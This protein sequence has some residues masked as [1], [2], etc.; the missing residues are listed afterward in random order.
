MPECPKLSENQIKKILNCQDSF[1][2]KMQ[3]LDKAA[4]KLNR[5][6]VQLEAD[7][8]Q[9]PEVKANYENKV[10][11]QKAVEKATKE[12]DA[13]KKEFMLINNAINDNIGHYNTLLKYQTNMDDLEKY[14]YKT[15]DKNKNQVEKINSK[16]AISQRMASYYK[17]KTETAS[18]YNYYLKYLYWAVLTAIGILYIYLLFGKL[19]HIAFIVI[20]NK[21]KDISM[22]Y[23]KTG[24]DLSSNWIIRLCKK[25]NIKTNANKKN[26]NK[27]TNLCGIKSTEFIL[28]L[29]T[30]TPYILLPII[31]F[32]KPYIYP[33]A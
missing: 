5:A 24:K 28:L 9:P 14:Y 10:K 16:K 25:T 7:F 29:L 11:N 2:G 30:L 15:I 22:E 31:T 6:A 33:Y 4:K 12:V 8:L 20:S 3:E 17:D 32:L 21:C 26:T 19:K 18:W 13:I 27:T 1:L 23:K